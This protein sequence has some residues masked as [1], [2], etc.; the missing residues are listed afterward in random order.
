VVRN[1]SC[2]GVLLGSG[3]GLSRRVQ[4][5]VKGAGSVIEVWRGG[6][7]RLSEEVDGE[8]GILK[9]GCGPRVEWAEAVTES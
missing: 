7:Q 3:W 2:R 9:V 8:I 5:S 6:G 1:R 4:D